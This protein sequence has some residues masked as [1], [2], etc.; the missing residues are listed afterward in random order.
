[1]LGFLGAPLISFAKN[2]RFYLHKEFRAAEIRFYLHKEFRAAEIR[3]YLHKEFLKENRE[4]S[5]IYVENF[6]RCARQIVKNFLRKLMK[7]QWYMFK[8]FRAARANLLSVS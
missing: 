1:M 4:K 6:P 7:N 3:F 2:I 5:M 8:I